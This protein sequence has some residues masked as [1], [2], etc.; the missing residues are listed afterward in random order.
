[1]S[2]VGDVDFEAMLALGVKPVGAGTQGGTVDS[3]FAPHLGDLVDGIE[4]IGWTDGVQAEAIALLEPDLI[5]VPDADTA[6]LLDGVATVVP[7]GSWA[8]PDWKLDFLYVGEVLGMRDEAAAMIADY[9]ADAAELSAE[10][11]PLID[12]KTVLSPQVAWDHSQVY[13][14]ADDSFS[15]AVLTELGF[16]LAPLAFDDNPDGIGVSWE[17]LESIDSDYL[18]WQ[19]RQSDDGSPDTEGLEIIRATPLYSSIPAVA[20]GQMYEVPNRPWYFPTILGARQIL[21]DVRAHLL[22]AG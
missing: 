18:F 7:R 17:Q 5:F 15:G 11:A 19:V 12:G 21:D 3:G 10:L 9:E 2:V 6:D 16:D 22:P 8:G 4:A 13:V 20:A 1:V 14:D